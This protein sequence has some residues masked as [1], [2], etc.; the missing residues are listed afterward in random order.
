ML[1]DEPG[2]AF[3]G[4]HEDFF[5]DPPFPED[6]PGFQGALQMPSQFPDAVGVRPQPRPQSPPAQ[7]P[8]LRRPKLHQNLLGHIRVSKHLRRHPGRQ[9]DLFTKGLKCHGIPPFWDII[10]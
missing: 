6:F 3:H 7:G 9:T 10:A 5:G 4:F 1:A 8:Q 2:E